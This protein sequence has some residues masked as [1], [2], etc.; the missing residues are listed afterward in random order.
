MPVDNLRAFY[1]KF[2]Q[3]D[4]AMLVVAGKFDEKKALEYIV[5]YF[6]AIPKPDRKL[7]ATYT[8]EPPQDGERTVRS[9]SGSATSAL[10]GL[11]YHIPAGPHPD[12]PARQV[13]AR[14]PRF[15]ALGPA[16]QGARRHQEG[17]E[18]VGLRRGP[19]R[20]RAS[21]EIDAEVNTK[22]LAD[23]GE[24]PRRDHQDRSRKSPTNG[25]TP[26]EVDRAK[27]K[28]LKNRELSRGRPQPD[29][30]RSSANLAAQGD[31]RLFF[32]SRDR[33]EKVTPADVRSRWPPKYLRVE[34]P[35]GRLLHPD[36]ASPSGRRSRR[37][38]TSPS[39]WSSYKG[40]EAQVA[41]ARR[42]TSPPRRSRPA[43]KRPD[44]D[45]GGEARPPAQEDPRRVGPS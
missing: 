4:N 7:P 14:H 23:A 34:Q 25:V 12:Y 8:E 26:E 6:G 33:I 36:H 44:A 13:L 3:P 15:A 41:P 32:L 45:P 10:V 30:D 16:L 28:F 19:A 2:Y 35:H 31:W 11:L 29:R 39:Y 20:S 43:C 38:R 24:G 17:G 40:R 21:F 42:S 5:K 18:R 1:K 37:R 27:R 22:D 9:C